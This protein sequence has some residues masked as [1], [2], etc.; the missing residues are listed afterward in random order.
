MSHVAAPDGTRLHYDDHGAGVPVL[1]LP[2]LTRNMDD[3]DPVVE[4]FADR[5]RVLRMDFRGRGGSDYADPQTYNIPQE[6]ADVVTLL[7]HLGLDRV[8]ILGTSRGGLVA[9]ALAATAR[10]RLCGVFLNDVGPVV[11]PKG[12]DNIMAYI[13]KPPPYKSFAEAAAAMPKVYPHF[14]GVPKAT[15]AAFVRRLWREGPDGLELR[16]DPRL[17]DAVAAAFDT[18]QPAPNLWPLFDAMTGMP[19]ALL[20]G[21][22]SDILSAKTAAEMRARRPDLMY[23]ELPDRGHVPFLDEPA[24][25]ALIA[26]WIGQLK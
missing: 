10:D 25:V 12:L 9:M 20:R 2:G 13:G 15:W 22:T 21:A 5:V 11:S 23:A 26:A 3:F 7:D 8:A 1:C 17:R 18:T 24:S 14:T 4:N 6:A 19:L 16:Y